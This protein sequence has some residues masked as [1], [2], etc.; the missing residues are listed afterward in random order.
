MT[1]AVRLPAIVVN[2]PGWWRLDTGGGGVLV[3]S[4]FMGG[5]CTLSC[6]EGAMSNLCPVCCRAYLF[7]AFEVNQG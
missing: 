3:I 5:G 1:L 7:V 4:T 2:S 6:W